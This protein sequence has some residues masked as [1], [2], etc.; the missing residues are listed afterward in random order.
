MFIFLSVIVFFFFFFFFFFVYFT[1][2]FL[3][4][5]IYSGF[6]IILFVLFV[7]FILTFF[8][9]FLSLNVFCYITCTP[10]FRF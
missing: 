4:A 9:S 8:F 5:F 6:L 2:C 3:G 7:S 10:S 1:E